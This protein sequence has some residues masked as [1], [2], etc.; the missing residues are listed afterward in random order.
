MIDT[1][2]VI[3][4]FV[5]EVAPCISKVSEASIRVALKHIYQ[6]VLSGHLNFFFCHCPRCAAKERKQ[7]RRTN[8]NF[9][10]DISE[11][12]RVQCYEFVMSPAVLNRTGWQNEDSVSLEPLTI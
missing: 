6:S 1:A 5:M 3:Y 12:K 11:T 10:V 9:Y 7:L 2:I 4:R 8:V